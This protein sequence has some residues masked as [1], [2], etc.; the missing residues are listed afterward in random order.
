MTIAVLACGVDQAYPPGHRDMLAAVT[1]QGV[2]VSEW[3]LGRAPTRRRF[4]IRNRVIGALSRGTVVVEAGL[5][6]GA[7]NTARHARDLGR[8]LMAV[9]GPVT[10]DVSAGCHK[11]IRE[12]GAVCVTGA[13]DVVEMLTPLGESGVG[14]R[15]PVRGERPGSVQECL[16]PGPLSDGAA[17]GTS[18]TGG[19]DR[20]VAR[21]WP[22]PRWMP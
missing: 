22:V 6:S 2:L 15:L 13:A 7:L 4:L 19:P 9:P 21:C 12:W 1:V 8:P 5:R 16:W 20:R 11:I 18:G 3:P 10:S 14:G 17:S